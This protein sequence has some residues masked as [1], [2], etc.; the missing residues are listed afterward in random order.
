MLSGA[1]PPVGQS[2]K[3]VKKGKGK[4]PTNE[5][6]NVNGRRVRHLSKQYEPNL[7]TLRTRDRAPPGDAISQN[8]GRRATKRNKKGRNK[9]IGDT[10]A[11]DAPQTRLKE[12]FDLVSESEGENESVSADELWL[13]TLCSKKCEDD[14]SEMMECE[15]CY[16]HFCLGCLEMNHTVY[17]YMQKVT[18]DTLWCCQ[19]CCEVIRAAFPRQKGRR[20]AFGLG[21]GSCSVSYGVDLESRMDCVEE[22]VTSVERILTQVCEQKLEVM[23]QKL[24]QVC[25]FIVETDS[26]TCTKP[27]TN[28]RSVGKEASETSENGVTEERDESRSNTWRVEQKTLTTKLRTV[29]REEQEKVAVEAEKAQRRRRNIILHRVPELESEIWAERKKHDEEVIGSMLECLEVNVEVVE[30]HRLGSRFRKDED[31]VS[32]I[33]IKRP[34][35]VTLA[36]E[37]DRKQILSH[38]S[39]LGRADES[40][41]SVRVSPDLSEEERKE[42]KALVEKAKNLNQKEEGEFRYIV[43]GME[44]MKVKRRGKQQTAKGKKPSQKDQA[45]KEEQQ[46]NQETTLPTVG[47]ETKEE[48]AQAAAAFPSQ[49]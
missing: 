47:K 4:D 23:E 5:P 43:K 31:E 45:G 26:P 33:Q 10:D 29:F 24:H 39:K 27:V 13:C 6:G 49:D 12:T 35:L 37:E 38:L 9:E 34:L 40:I 46:R 41:R 8:G 20:S 44:I 28:I 25:N 17:E 22:K 30:H 15:R 7:V 11:T 18:P 36:R 19:E 3:G 14:D 2:K 48:V 1:K 42:V 32:N 16:R 21:V